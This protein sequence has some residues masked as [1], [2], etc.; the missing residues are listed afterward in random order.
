MR[1]QP[2]LTASKSS[3]VRTIDLPGWRLHPLSG[4]LADH[5]SVWGNGNWRLTFTFDG[6]DPILVG[7]QDYH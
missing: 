6:Q 1:S 2:R 4:H 3:A 5:W 7:Y